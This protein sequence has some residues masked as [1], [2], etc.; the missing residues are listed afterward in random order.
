MLTI[1]SRMPS[2][3]L[4]L[5]KVDPGSQS[6]IT[7]PHRTESLLS[8]EHVRVVLFLERTECLRRHDAHRQIAPD[9]GELDHALDFVPNGRCVPELRLA[10]FND[11]DPIHLLVE[12]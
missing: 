2:A 3:L 4:M 8:D 10:C 5:T 1:R 7:A 11:G 6:G 9:A 12:D